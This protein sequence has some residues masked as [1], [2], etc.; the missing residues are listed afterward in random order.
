VYGPPHE[1]EFQ[2]N[3]TIPDGAI[4][5]THDARRIDWYIEE[6]LTLSIQEKE[7]FNDRSAVLKRMMGSS[8]DRDSFKQHERS[9]QDALDGVLKT[10]SVPQK[11][12]IPRRTFLGALLLAAGH[13]SGVPAVASAAEQCVRGVVNISLRYIDPGVLDGM[14]EEEGAA[15]IRRLYSDVENG[16]VMRSIAEGFLRRVF[17]KK[18]IPWMKGE[19][20]KVLIRLGMVRESEWAGLMRNTRDLYLLEEIATGI[21]ETGSVKGV[22]FLLDAAKKETDV[23]RK[24]RIIG[25]L[26]ETR[27]Y[28]AAEYIIGQLEEDKEM[29]GPRRIRMLSAL[30]GTKTETALNY[31]TG[32]FERPGKHRSET[33]DILRDMGS[34]EAF[35]YLKKRLKIETDEKVKREINRILLL[36]AGHHPFRFPDYIWREFKAR[37]LDRE[38]GEGE[39]A[40][41]I[42]KMNGLAWTNVKGELCWID[43]ILDIEESKTVW[44]AAMDAI[45]MANGYDDTKEI[46]HISRVKEVIAY[47]ENIHALF[48]DAKYKKL[49]KRFREKL[50]KE[51]GKLDETHPFITAFKKTYGKPHS[52][53]LLP[54]D[55]RFTIHDSRIDWYLEEFLTLSIQERD[56]FDDRSAVLTRMIKAADEQEGGIL[57]RHGKSILSVLDKVLNTGQARRF[58][59]SVEEDAV[60]GKTSFLERTNNRLEHFFGEMTFKKAVYIFLTLFMIT[61]TILSVPYYPFFKFSY[62]VAR[63]ENRQVFYFNGSDIEI[64]DMSGKGTQNIAKMKYNLGLL[65]RNHMNGIRKIAIMSRE[66]IKNLSFALDNPSGFYLNKSYFSV[67]NF[68]VFKFLRAVDFTVRTDAAGISLYKDGVGGISTFHEVGH[69]VYGDILTE[70]QRKEWGS[71]NEKSRGRP[72]FVSDHAYDKNAE[73]DF[74]EMYE[75]F[76]TNSLELIMGSEGALAEKVL[77]TARLFKED[78]PDGSFLMHYFMPVVME[79]KDRVQIHLYRFTH[80]SGK[81]VDLGLDSLRK[82]FFDMIS[83]DA[84]F[85]GNL[86]NR[87]F[88]D[89]EKMDLPGLRF[90]L[91]GCVTNPEIVETK[92]P[93]KD[94]NKRPVEYIDKCVFVSEVYEEVKQFEKDLGSLDSFLMSYPGIEFTAAPRAIAVYHIPTV[95]KDIKEALS[96]AG[97][98][99]KRKIKISLGIV[100]EDV[101]QVSIGETAIS[102]GPVPGTAGFRKALEEAIIEGTVPAGQN[103]ARHPFRFPDY[104]WREFKARLLDREGGEGELAYDIV[105][106][107]GLA[108]TNVKGKLCWIDE[109]LDAEESKIVWTAAMDA[110]NMANGYEDAK[111]IKD[112]SSVKEVIAYHENIHALFQDAKYKKL[113]KR[114]R[115]KLEKEI[116][117]L[118]ENHPFITAFRKTYG[119]PHSLEL[120]PADSRFTIHDSRID[121]YLEEFL[122][123]LI[124]ERDLFGGG[125]AVLDRMI[126]SAGEGERD[127]LK[128]QEE[129]IMDT[130]QGILRTGAAREFLNSLGSGIMEEVP[131]TRED[132]SVLGRL[133]RKITGS[134]PPRYRTGSKILLAGGIVYLVLLV[135]SYMEFTWIVNHTKNRQTVHI[136]GHPVEIIDISDEVTEN[137]TNVK[138]DLSLLP[139]AH[140][141]GPKKLV[142]ASMEQMTRLRPVRSFI[143]GDAHEISGQY[144]LKFLRL[145]S[146]VDCVIQ[147]DLTKAKLYL[148]KIGNNPTVHEIGRDVYRDVLTEEQRLLWRSLN[149]KSALRRDFVSYDAYNADA[150]GDFRETYEAFCINS[151][152]LILKSGEVLSEKA[153]FVARLFI[154]DTGGKNPVMHYFMP[155]V[156]KS[157][158]GKDYAQYRVHRLSQELEPGAKIDT[159]TLKN[160]LLDLLSYDPESSEQFLKRFFLGEQAMSLDRIRS[161]MDECGTNPEI[162]GVNGPVTD[163]NRRAIK[164]HEKYAVAGSAPESFERFEKDLDSLDSFMMS[165]PGVEFTAAPRAINEYHIPT[166]IEDIREALKRSGYDGKGKLRMSLGITEGELK[167]SIGEI[168]ISPELYP[169]TAEFRKALK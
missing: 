3:N 36:A 108:W 27:S 133:F 148:F 115:K 28:R 18:D 53:E 106:M 45:N 153:L 11:K 130:V 73:E 91:N 141:T 119:K 94:I 65:P 128:L 163:L 30:G 4:R 76:C 159:E 126:R 31:I 164:Y 98:D 125:D 135:L 99:G 117:K 78:Q 25:G 143:T 105:K 169:G 41:D 23:K 19:A 51:I 129:S 89:E 168:V 150:E 145:A 120:L 139:R 109:I 33:L 100:T 68:P 122:T 46:R 160:N 21:A 52:L 75:A 2:E 134:I 93:V 149:E 29:D 55:S 5:T 35:V 86:L 162:A 110:I 132:V 118:D 96:S 167:V 77:F 12:G 54:A 152:H 32:E 57:R 62:D 72:D 103:G 43:E 20:I 107:Y 15:Y 47:H 42:V 64:I 26:G 50:E 70:E 138:Y 1:L 123:L 88:H 92:G 146:G 63:S 136:N 140:I 101:L 58:V 48:R 113:I 38:G 22:D 156:V 13:L 147:D 165:Y 90:M 95:I 10:V 6:F 79:E 85:Y 112:I 142:V 80:R 67:F 102:P 157:E 17:E 69:H 81:G 24:D 121:W 161:E 44:T 34:N 155:V 116:G 111:K 60:S 104:I 158:L 66:Q 151:W 114:F 37:L 16:R 39:L 97:Y 166:I 137:I 127:V 61:V 131:A 83:F 7:L 124:Q 59:R 9:I 74:C 84:K 82:S 40:Y 154:E 14:T 87:L 71:L 8:E 144:S 56:L 49:I